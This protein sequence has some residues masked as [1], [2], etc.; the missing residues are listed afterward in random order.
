MNSLIVKYLF[1]VAILVCLVIN[2]IL[3]LTEHYTLGLIPF[4]VMVFLM[5][6]YLVKIL[7][8]NPWA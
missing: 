1:S 2:F 7:K 8:F 3:M 4:L 5:W 6:Y